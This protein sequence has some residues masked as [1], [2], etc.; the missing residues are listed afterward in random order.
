MSMKYATIERKYNLYFAKIIW[1]YYFHQCIVFTG[2]SSSSYIN[3]DAQPQRFRNIHTVW[4]N[5]I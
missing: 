5:D 2:H 1:M 3:L 4:E